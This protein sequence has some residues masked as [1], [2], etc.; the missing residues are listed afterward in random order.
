MIVTGEK[1]SMTILAFARP[2]QGQTLASATISVVTGKTAVGGMDLPGVNE[3]TRDR[4][5]TS[6]TIRGRRS[7]GQIDLHRRR[8]VM[9]MPIEVS[10]M[11]LGTATAPAPVN[12]GI[13]VP[14]RPDLSRP[15][16][17]VMTRPATGMNSGDHIAGMA[18]H[19]K[20][21]SSN[22]RVIMSMGI[23][24]R[25]MAADTRRPPDNCGHMHPNTWIN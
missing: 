10:G 5:M 14:V 18:I 6:D 1:G 20:R 15:V 12:R 16:R 17:Q 24:V 25:G 13:A 8:M 23:K 9:V 11:T 4:H 22:R 7:H 21:G 3:R 2:A 19:A